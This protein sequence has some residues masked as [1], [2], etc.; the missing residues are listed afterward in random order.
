[1]CVKRSTSAFSLLRRHFLYRT[2][3]VRTFLYTG[4]A[5]VPFNGK[6]SQEHRAQARSRRQL[7]AG[8]RRFFAEVRG[9]GLHRTLESVHSL[10]RMHVTSG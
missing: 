6:G 4:T 5:Y 2:S 3:K 10:A 9:R 1:V 8:K 7:A